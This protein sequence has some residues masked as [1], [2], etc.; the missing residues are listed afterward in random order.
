MVKVE[1]L[2][3]S[4]AISFATPR[5]SH[6]EQRRSSTALANAHFARIAH[7]SASPANPRLDAAQ[8]P[9][10]REQPPKRHSSHHLEHL[11]DPHQQQDFFF[12]SFSCCLNLVLVLLQA[13][14]TS[15]TACQN[16]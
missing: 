12:S 7:E 14:A 9:V 2:V 13:E 6:T 10:A 15:V 11:S 4:L 1:K 16:G 3:A 5:S 8:R